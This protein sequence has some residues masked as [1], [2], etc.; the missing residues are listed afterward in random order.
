MP[1]TVSVLYPN[2]PD[3]KY[4]VEYYISRHM[5]LA[6]AQ[7]KSSGLKSW[8]VTK[9]QA[10]PDGK[11]PQYVFAGILNFDSIESIHKALASPETQAVMQDVP[12][13]SNKTPVF[14]I[15][16]DAKTTTV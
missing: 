10:S 13:F 5:P 8:S 9:Y 6:A 4:D 1:A 12:N 15:G 3:S 14:L 7:W 11:E 16:E 2:E